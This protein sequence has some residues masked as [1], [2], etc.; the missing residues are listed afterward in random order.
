LESDGIPTG[1][2]L[3]NVRKICDEKKIIL[4]FDECTSG[5]RKTFGGLHKFFKV[6][7]DMAMFGKALGNGYAVNAIIGKRSVMDCAK[8]TFISSTFWTERIGTIAAL[9]TL[10]V[11]HKNK[12]WELI[13]K[14][15]K[16]IKYGWE[17]IAK[18]YDIKIIIKGIDA[19]PNFYFPHNDNLYFKTYIT[20]EM[21][22][23]KILAGNSVYVCSDHNKNILNKYFNVLD[24]VFKKIK[25]CID[26]KENIKSLLKSP[27]CMAGMR[28]LKNLD[29]KKK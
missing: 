7:P 9:K 29:E 14:I 28:S 18:D 20:Q 8:S 13:S 27:V 5:F 25:Q 3:K 19:L 1:T 11:M 4:I 6:S 24:G 12:N 22:K 2:F 15:G 16:S 17:K 21:L 26:E 23:N 10:E